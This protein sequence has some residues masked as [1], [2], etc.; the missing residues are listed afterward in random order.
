MSFVSF[1]VQ[2][3][4]VT[5]ITDHSALNGLLKSKQPTGIL[6]RWLEI[7]ADYDFE[8]IYRPGRVNESADYLSRLGY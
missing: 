8:I 6:A 1:I 5:V 4:T 3:S 7:L 2:E